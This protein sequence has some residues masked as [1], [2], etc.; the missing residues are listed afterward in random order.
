MPSVSTGKLKTTSTG[1]QKSAATGLST[2]IPEKRKQKEK[3]AE[4][5]AR[6]A[7]AMLTTL[8]TPPKPKE[9]RKRE[10]PLY[11][12]ARRSLRIKTGRPQSQSKDPITIED[13]PTSPR[14]RSPS[15]V[16]VT[17][18]RGSPKTTTWRERMEGL[19]SKTPLQDAEAILQKTLARLKETERMEG[20][21]ATPPPR[22]EEIEPQREEEVEHILEPSPQPSL[23]SYYN[24]LEARKIIPQK[25][26]MPLFF[27]LEEER[28]RTHTWMRIAKSKGVVDIGPLEE[29]LKEARRELAMEKHVGNC[30][31]V[32]LQE[33]NEKLK[34]QLQEQRRERGTSLEDTTT[35]PQGKEGMQVGLEELDQN[36]QERE[37]QAHIEI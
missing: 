5:L 33:E 28:V 1:S 27:A 31:W 14:E 17:Y 22:E 35:E 2:G 7:V 32:F 36:L 26:T 24:F 23:S 15:K 6:E 8:S 16:L 10:T 25:F 18:E 12:K 20:E 29:Q 21:V 13:T 11:F 30:Q 37:L 34:L 9:K 19:A 4:I 3:T